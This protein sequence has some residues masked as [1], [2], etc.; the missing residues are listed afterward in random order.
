MDI[1]SVD[2]VVLF[3]KPLPWLATL[4]V[5]Y[6]ITLILIRTSGILNRHSC[7][8]CGKK[9][10]RSKRRRNDKILKKVSLGILPVKRFRCYGCYWDGVGFRNDKKEDSKIELE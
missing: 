8:N 1:E 4:I 6:L 2:Y 9:I 10:K 7:P 3:V 5:L